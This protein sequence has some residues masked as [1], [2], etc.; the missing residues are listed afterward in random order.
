[1]INVNE[2]IVTLLLRLH[3]KYS[4]RPD[5]YIPKQHRSGISTGED[6]ARS[7]IG[8][9]SFFVEKVL[10]KICNLDE[11]CLENVAASRQALWPDYHEDE[12]RQDAER[13]RLEAEA[14]K[15]KAK[16]RQRQM[17]EQLAQQRRKF[18]A[19]N[20]DAV[21]SD[22]K[23][24]PTKPP[25]ENPNAQG[26]ASKAPNPPKSTEYT[27][28]HCLVQGPATDS[29]PIGLVILFQSSSVLAHKHESTNHLILSTTD[30]EKSSLPPSWSDSLGLQ[31]DE[32]FAE[33]NQVYDPQS[34]LMST[35]RGWK[36]GI[37]IQSCGH[38]MHYDCR[39]SYW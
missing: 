15:R 3:S 35:H 27:C 11:T 17:M 32:L 13:E 21:K 4:G 9:G 20:T 24:E 36:G 23:K 26:G 7:R 16:E 28:C 37:H 2:S 8:D 22:E 38:H 14:K 6:Y 33:M 29:K 1:M 10:D 5:S 18:M 30:E 34:C 39:T 25:T 31:Y 12:A 19:K